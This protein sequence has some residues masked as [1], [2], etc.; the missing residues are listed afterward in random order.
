MHCATQAGRIHMSVSF[1][2][3]LS[4]VVR[5]GAK[6]ISVD[7]VHVFYA[8]PLSCLNH[9]MLH[10]AMPCHIVPC[11]TTFRACVNTGRDSLM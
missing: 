8:C 4:L 6:L 11:P 10:Q 2:A 9:C 3:I 7:Q 5:T 1:K